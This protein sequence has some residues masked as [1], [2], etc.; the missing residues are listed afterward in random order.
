MDH[1][2]AAV[3]PGLCRERGEGVVGDGDDDQL[4]LLD[5]GLRLGE[6]SG[7][8]GQAGQSLAPVR[9]AAG[10]RLDR[11]VGPGQGER[12]RGADRA[13]AD[14]ARGRALAGPG[15]L[16]G[17]PVAVGVDLVA[18]AV[19]TR[20]ERIEVDAGGLDGR[21]GPPSRSS[22]LA[23]AKMVEEPFFGTSA[24]SGRATGASFTGSTVS[25]TVATALSA[26]PSLAR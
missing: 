14:D 16:M 23:S 21:L 20:R 13:A 26:V 4:D 11:P 12:Q 25:E 1:G 7:A 5:Q 22:S 19:V 3:Q 17:M 24:A 2:L 8:A 9:I 18:V 10:D 15:V 6:G